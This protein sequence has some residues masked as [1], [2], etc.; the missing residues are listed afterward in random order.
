[1]L[2]SLTCVLNFYLFYLN[3]CCSF[4]STNILI[5]LSLK[6]SKPCL[7]LCVFTHYTM[8]PKKLCTYHTMVKAPFSEPESARSLFYNKMFGTSRIFWNSLPCLIVSNLSR[9]I[10]ENTFISFLF[11]KLIFMGL[12]GC[13]IYHT[14]FRL[15]FVL[16]S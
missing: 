11:G 2:R 10:S 12:K 5:C 8:C 7:L 16:R 15:F 14:I 4:A 1:M 6:R 9:K 3:Y 13:F